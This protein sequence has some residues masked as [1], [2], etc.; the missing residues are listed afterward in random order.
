MFRCLLGFSRCGTA[1][2]GTVAPSLCSLARRWACASS[3]LEASLLFSLTRRFSGANRPA[4]GD[5]ALCTSLRLT[6]SRA[7][8]STRVCCASKKATPAS[9]KRKPKHA[10]VL[11]P[12]RR[13]SAKL[14]SASRKMLSGSRRAG[15]FAPL[16]RG[17]TGKQSPRTTKKLRGHQL[18]KVKYNKRV[19][20]IAKLFRAQ[21]KA[22][23]QQ[24][25]EQQRH[26]LLSHRK[27]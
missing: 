13:G 16:K 27:K 24:E 10:S 22:R 8:G 12:R 14:L 26:S 5:S 6:T 11:A 7:F 4:M 19:A 20:A 21:Q 17:S 15:V 3:G 9:R 2:G 25:L 1:Q 18:Q 23:R